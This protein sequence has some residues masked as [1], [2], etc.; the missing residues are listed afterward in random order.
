MENIMKRLHGLMLLM[1]LVWGCSE[2]GTSPS[3][4]AFLQTAFIEQTSESTATTYDFTQ[5]EAHGVRTV[6][7]RNWQRI[8]TLGWQ[9]NQSFSAVFEATDEEV[10]ISSA[11]GFE[12]VWTI[13]TVAPDGLEIRDS[14]GVQRVLFNC[15]SSNWPQLV[16]ASTRACNR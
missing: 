5:L 7:I 1:L 10:V 11:T 9:S 2:D 15:A 12:D 14:F 13:V 16:R 6:E 8:G 4:P 3:P